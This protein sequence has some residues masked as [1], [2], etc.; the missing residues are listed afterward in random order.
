VP[1][2]T[3]TEVLVYDGSLM[4]TVN[5][6]RISGLEAGAYYQYKVSAI[7]RAGEGAK[8][9]L[10]AQLISAQLPARSAIPVWTS[11]SQTQ[12]SFTLQPSAD[13][14]GSAIQEYTLYATVATSDGVSSETYTKVESYSGLTMSFDLVAA[15]ENAEANAQLTF[16]AGTIYRFRFSATNEIGE[17]QASNSVTVA[18][19][20][21]AVR[22]NQP[23]VD[24]A[25][26]TQTSLFI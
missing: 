18:L 17:G 12:I 2:A 24:R 23:A 15:T 13:N 6:T 1:V 7:N 14:G 21:P 10:S 22:P 11:A 4:P 16:A 5:S 20:D 3:G 25:Q 8:S 9:P 19:A 26:S